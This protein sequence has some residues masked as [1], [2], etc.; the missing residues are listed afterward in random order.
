MILNKKTP[1]KTYSCTTPGS[2]IILGEHSILKNHRAHILAINKTLT[3][4]LSLLKGKAD[5]SSSFPFGGR[6]GWGDPQNDVLQNGNADTSSPLP[7]NPKTTPPQSLRE[8][9][10]CAA[11]SLPTDQI[12]SI[13]SKL[14]EYK[15]TF[16]NIKT[17]PANLF[18]KK[19]KYILAAIKY[20]LSKN[21]DFS[22]CSNIDIDIQSDIPHDYGLGSSGAVLSAIV[23]VINFCHG[24]IDANLSYSQKLE[25]L[26]DAKNIA[27]TLSPTKKHPGSGYDYAASIFGGFI[28]YQTNPGKTPVITHYEFPFYLLLAYC[29][30]KTDTSIVIDKVNELERANPEKFKDLYSKMHGIVLEGSECLRELLKYSGDKNLTRYLELCEEYQSLLRELGVSDDTIESIIEVIGEA[31]CNQKEI[32]AQAAPARNDN[33]G[34]DI[35]SLDCDATPPQSLRGCE[36][37]AAISSNKIYCKI[38]GAGLGDC[39]IGLSE[40]KISNKIISKIKNLNLITL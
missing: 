11:I 16:E 7:E 1:N 32:A 19:F 15:T 29:G 10:A 37:S 28:D 2:V 21:Y 13:K 17:T 9:K 40:K 23:G 18:P 36:V 26:Q 35:A 27:K 38:S 22:N 34:D 30:Y 14:G 31:S 25:L 5:E 24:K 12:L 20:Y 8:G 4:S 33:S 39:V 6:L 3:V